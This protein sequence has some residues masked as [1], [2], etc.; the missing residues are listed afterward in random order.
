MSG[1]LNSLLIQTPE[2][3]EFSLL[4]A[5]P[6]SRF[7][8]WLM[9]L[10]IVLG[11]NVGLLIALSMLIALEPGMGLALF[12]LGTFVLWFGYGVALEWLWRGQTVGK[13]V[14]R[15][16]VMDEHGL[17]L[18][19]YQVLLRNLLRMVDM[20]PVLY[21]V[22]GAACVL[23][24]RAQRLGDLVAGTVVIRSPRLVEPDLSR[25]LGDKFNSFRQCPHLEARLRNRVSPGE[26]RIALQAV[27]RRDQL[28]P[29]SRV[30]LFGEIAEHFRTVVQFPQKAT[31]GLSDEQYVRNVV[32]TIFR[33]K[34]GRE[35]A[36][37]QNIQ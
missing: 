19:F 9:D 32:D 36:S 15:L 14:M 1:R 31:E 29:A 26:A 35:N 17:R 2:G 23:T 28:A 12:V 16:R 24:R 5:G 7:L 33:G 13:R 37:P 18:G 3:C 30:E 27:L 8:G 6:V 11:L 20:L 34:G 25:V 10:L 21:L 4:L 22:G